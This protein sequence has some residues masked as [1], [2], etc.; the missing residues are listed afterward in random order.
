MSK[1]LCFRCDHKLVLESNF[2]A[3]D[4]G[5]VPEEEGMTDED[6]MVTFMSCPYCGAKYEVSDT[7]DS[8]KGDYPYFS[9][10]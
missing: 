4:M 6:Y 10:I 2:M 5:A 1:Y 9:E 3:S 8:E 7:P